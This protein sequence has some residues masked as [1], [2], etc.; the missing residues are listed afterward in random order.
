MTDRY[1]FIRTTT[2]NTS[3]GEEIIA[4][5]ADREKLESGVTVEGLRNAFAAAAHPRVRQGLLTMNMKELET[6]KGNCEKEGTMSASVAALERAI[7]SIRLKE[8]SA[9]QKANGVQTRTTVAVAA[10][11]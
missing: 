11:R 4:L 7:G 3:Q 6:L 5:I 10:P 2:R 8:Q 1:A 9:A